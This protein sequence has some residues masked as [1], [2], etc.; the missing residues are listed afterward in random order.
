MWRK[1]IPSRWLLAGFLI[2]LPSSLLIAAGANDKD[3][4]TWVNNRVQAIQPTSAEKRF[5]EIG[6]AGS[7]VQAEK[8]ARQHNR[9]VFLFTFNGRIDTGRC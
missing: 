7:I 3:V 6:W 5:D 9:P 8:L 1:T 4:A 2:V